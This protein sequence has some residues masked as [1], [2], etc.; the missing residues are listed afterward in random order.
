MKKF[1]ICTFML[2]SCLIAGCTTATSASMDKGG[3]TI[4]NITTS[5]K[6]LAKSDCIPTSVT[7]TSDVSGNSAVDSVTIWYRIGQD[8]KYTPAPMK[9]TEGNTFSATIVALDIPGGEYGTL[10]FYITAK[11]KQGHESKSPLDT[12]VQLLACVAH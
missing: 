2:V 7:I 3:P 12:S 10:E 6:I 5:T 1:L 8:Q 9:Q 4:Q 11:D